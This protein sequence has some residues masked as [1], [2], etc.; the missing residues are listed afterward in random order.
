MLDVRKAT[1]RILKLLNVGEKNSLKK[2]NAL[3]KP[4]PSQRQNARAAPCTWIDVRCFD[5]PH[6]G[7]TQSVKNVTKP[8]WPSR[9]EGNVKTCAVP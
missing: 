8:V 3:G 1:S 4:N 9:I 2:G 6:A 7:F 5:F